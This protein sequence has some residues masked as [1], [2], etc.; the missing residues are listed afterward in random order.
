MTRTSALWLGALAVV[1]TGVA[2]ALAIAWTAA[3]SAPLALVI[4]YAVY[5][6]GTAAAGA[7]I[8]AAYP[9]HR[10]GWLLIAIGSFNALG[11]DASLAYGVRA[12]QVGWPGGVYGEVISYST[13]FIAALALM[14]LLLLFPDGQLLSPRWRWTTLSWAVGAALLVPGWVLSAQMSP[15][16]VGGTNPLARDLPLQSAAFAVGLALVC[17]PLAVS[18][19]A[20][21]LRWRRAVGVA[22][23]QLTWFVAA[24]VIMVTLL[25]VGAALWNVTP[26]APVLA[27]TG[28][29]VL[30]AAAY[31]AILRHHLY[32]VD[33]VVSRT[34]TYVA[35]TSLLAL[36]YVAVVLA[37]GTLAPTPV[38]AAAAALVTAVLALR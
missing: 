12:H 31:V 19:G 25:P 28:L 23:N 9:G 33:L 8:V 22:R 11:S 4:T 36:A 2:E 1:I 29:C 17:A 21:F 35:L 37:I 24:A 3:A 14:W 26:I 18:V 32:D 27:A 34:V 13:W 10:V 16:M 20:P 6:L 30:P 5:S 15:A 7:R 38:A